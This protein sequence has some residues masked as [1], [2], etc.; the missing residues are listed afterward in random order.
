[1]PQILFDDYNDDDGNKLFASLI[2]KVTGLKDLGIWDYRIMLLF[3][4]LNSKKRCMKKISEDFSKQEF[5]TLK[6][7]INE[8]TEAFTTYFSSS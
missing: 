8:N 4:I 6:I 3:H 7:T 5:I 2:Y 1:M